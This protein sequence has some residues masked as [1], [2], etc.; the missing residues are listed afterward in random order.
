MKYIAVVAMSEDR[1]I[2]INGQMPW[3]L[4]NDLAH[5]RK[6]TLGKCVVMGR[7]TSSTLPQPLEGRTSIVMSR[8][9]STTFP[10]YDVTFVR[11]KDLAVQKAIDLGHNELY[12]IGGAQ[13]YKL[14]EHDIQ[15]IHLTKVGAKIYGD[16]H[17]PIDLNNFRVEYDYPHPVL[18]HHS[19][20]FNFMKYTRK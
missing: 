3:R 17:F 15:E 6:M 14:F 18:P 5:F 16:T 12:I 11:T 4:P 9:Q 10:G 8:G 1:T 19:H 13:I 2:G 20:K 7:R